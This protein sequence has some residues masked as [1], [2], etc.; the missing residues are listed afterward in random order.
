VRQETSYEERFILSIFFGIN[1]LTLSKPTGTI[2]KKSVT[3]FPLN[4]L[5]P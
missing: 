1:G 5:T 3:R 2:E 4:P